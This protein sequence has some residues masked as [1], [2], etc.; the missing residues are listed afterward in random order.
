MVSQLEIFI[1][2]KNEINKNY[3][4]DVI[5]CFFLIYLEGDDRERLSSRVSEFTSLAAKGLLEKGLLIREES[6]VKITPKG[7]DLLMEIKRSKGD[8]LSQ[9]YSEDIS[10][11]EMEVFFSTVEKLDTLLENWKI[12]Q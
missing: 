12:N 1:Q 6:K 11:D 7:E 2:V 9:M 8:I 4:L 5:E 10:W 3:G